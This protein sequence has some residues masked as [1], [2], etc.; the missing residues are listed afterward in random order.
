VENR[1]TPNVTANKI[2]SNKRGNMYFR[3]EFTELKISFGEWFEFFMA[4]SMKMAV[5][6][7]VVPCRVV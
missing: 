1:P 3:L 6:R 4:V 7:V 2:W 5:F